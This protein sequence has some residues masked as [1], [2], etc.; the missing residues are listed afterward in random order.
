VRGSISTTAM[1]V[2]AGGVLLAYVALRRLAAGISQLSDAAIAWKQVA[3]LFHAVDPKSSIRS[4][5]TFL[6]NQHGTLRTGEVLLDGRDLAF[7]YS[8]RSEPVL[9]NCDLH[10]RAGDKLLIE[11]PS[12]EGS[13]PWRPS[14]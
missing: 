9:K 2:G 8:D 13:P 4:E 6:S 14:W 10:I 11:G 1:A 3:L 12:G 5:S 7:R